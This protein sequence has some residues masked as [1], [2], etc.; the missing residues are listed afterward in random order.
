MDFAE[1]YKTNYGTEDTPPVVYFH[2]KNL[3]HPFSST[4]DIEISCGVE[5]EDTSEAVET[6][7][8]EEDT[9]TSNASIANSISVLFSRYGLYSLTAFFTFIM[10]FI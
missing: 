9:T 1:V 10:C 5:K 2:L 3:T 6:E 4:C 8:G 7:G